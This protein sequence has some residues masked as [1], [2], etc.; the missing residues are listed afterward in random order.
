MIKCK[1]GKC[2]RH[3]PA[4][5]Q[6]EVLLFIHSNKCKFMKKNRE[7]KAQESFS[8]TGDPAFKKLFR[9]V[10]LSVFC[11]FL[12]LTQIMAMESYSQQ[13]KLSL[14][15]NN[16]RLEEVLKTI[17]DK[18]EFFF[19]YN[20]DLIDVEQTV[21]ISVTNQTITTILDELLKGTDISYSVVNRQI[22][23]SN[24]EG[25]SGLVSQQQKN[26]SGKVTDSA[27][28]SLPG[29]SIVVKGTT[30]GI[31]TDTNG[32]Y[33][34]ANVP[35]DAT[36]VFS[37]VG[38]KMQEII[39]GGKK[40]INVTLNEE[41]V[42]IEEVVAI[43][44]GTQ[45]KVNLTGAVS[46]VKVDRILGDRPL[47]SVATALQGTIPGLQ[48]TSS[49]GRPGVATTIDIRGMMSIN[50]GSPLVLVDNVPMDIE[51]L[52]PSDIET[53]SVLKDASASS[54]YGGRAAFGV[55]LIT[56]KKGLRNQPIKFNYT[57][58]V[59]TNHPTD[60]PEKA[61]TM[62]MITAFKAWGNTSYTTGQD[63]ITWSNLLTEYQTDPSK[64]P[65]GE[66]LV[67][68][69]K[70]RLAENNLYKEF[71]NNSFE[72]MHNLSFSGGSEKSDFRVSLGYANEDGIMK[73][74]KD[75]YKK[76]NL[77][78]YLN[79][80]LTKRL[81]ST[82]NLLY[83]NDVQLTPANYGG[84]FNTGIRL[85]RHGSIGYSTGTDGAKIPYGSPNNYLELEPAN[86]SLNNDLRILEKLE[87]SVTK[88][89]KIAGEYTFSRSISNA[90]TS[91]S[92]TIYRDPI[93]ETLSP[94]GNPT[95]YNRTS[96]NTDYNALNLYANYEKTY[97]DHVFHL[98]GGTNQELSKYSGFW[99]QR[100]NLL[101]KDNPSLATSNGT[102]TNGES[103]SDYAISGYFMRFN[104]SFKNKYLLEANLRYD[105]SSKFP[106]NNRYG[107]FPSFSAGW[108]LTEE[109][110]MKPIENIISFMKIRSSWGEIGNQSIANYAFIPTMNSRNARWIDAANVLPY[111]T[112]DPPSLVS[113]S[114]TWETV[115]TKNIGVDINFFDNRLNATFDYFN[116]AT[117]DMLGP[118][119]ELPA[120][121][122][123]SAPKKNV[124]DLESKGW[125]LNI[126]WKVNKK[127]L[128][129]SIGINVSDT[130]AFVT[131]FDNEGGMLSQYYDGYEFGEIWGYETNG[132]YTVD[133]FVSGTL[134]AK[135]MNGTLKEDVPAYYTIIKQNPGD[136][137]YADLNDDGK[138]SPG[139]STLSDPGDRK[140]IG[141]SNK[142]YQFGIIGN[143]VY[144]NFD[145]SLFLQGVGKQDIWPYINSSNNDDVN[146]V[147]WPYNDL[148]ASLYKN[149]LDYW[150]PEHTDAYYM[151]SY[152]GGGGNTVISR[153]P[154]TK[155]LLNGACLRIKSIG[156][157]YTLPASITEKFSVNSARLFMS[158]ENLFKFDH[159]PSG[160]DNEVTIV[161]NGGIYP[162]YRKISFGVSISF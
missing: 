93:T 127:D 148:Y 155:Y 55:I 102:M 145:F 98:M 110:F 57:C 88:G 158:A 75:S 128:S 150:T 26:V 45:K 111:L 96:G 91:T 65:D 54:I 82:I 80:N 149:E 36:L 73:T 129:Y 140:I 44:Y 78:A 87:Y 24:L 138:I 113:S 53:V 70:Y 151:R 161:S 58:N 154:Q 85:P 94:F 116:R 38:M 136:I 134:D 4:G 56:T 34:L 40:N 42:G 147:F 48:I 99:A 122:G 46:Q 22:I 5:L 104:Y 14:S 142:H 146:A 37:F 79:T 97:M 152:K 16:Q 13:T 144:K 123:A 90:T 6:S 71:M 63:L 27:G 8:V 17:E 118:S 66:T 103:F 72:Q 95:Y 125:E 35:S 156:I 162:Y 77:N 112:I 153:Y 139:S 21:N 159:L 10:R 83:E 86:P 108:V 7:R 30:N 43:G 106:K 9:M 2:F 59:T 51:N 84:L 157:G 69:V 132:F 60:L 100:T 1:A 89:L 19:L 130:R 137:R 143:C 20:K 101:D 124:A 47:S 121:I 28:S 107:L 52:N 41:T 160:M 64:Y 92:G 33:T 141:N 11:F 126:D 119:A 81:T 68:G 74:N 135:L 131:K 117:L 133:D 67:N 115:R 32:N 114:F 49:S 50:G 105:G 61:S 15:L 62:E 76:I 18:S 120:T 12:S 23:L 3:F 31:I 25:I 109:S 29:V 39:V